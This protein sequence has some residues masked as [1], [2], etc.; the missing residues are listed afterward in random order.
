MSEAAFAELG[1]LLG[2]ARA[3]AALGRSRATHY[4]RLRRHRVGPR[5]AR[6]TPPNALGEPERAAIL[7]VLHEPRFVDEAPAQVY[8]VLLDEGRYLG[9]VSTMYRMLRSADEVR[10]RRRQARHPARAI[11]ELL[12]AGPNR[13]WS[14][15]STKLR[16]PV[17]G[18]WFILLTMLDIFSRFSPGHLVAA[19]EDGEIVKAWIDDVVAT[20]PAPFD[21][22]LLSIHADRGPAMKSEPV[23]ALLD[24][25]GIARSH[26]RPHVSNDNP[27]SEA[28]FKTLKYC[29]TFPE[30][31][32][33][34]EDARAFCARFY[35]KYN[36]E[37]RH[38]G[39]GFHTPA[40][41]HFGTA[42]AVRGG[43]ASVLRAA[44]L[45]HPE[46]FVRGTPVPPAL[47]T[48]AWINE[49]K[50]QPNQIIR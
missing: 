39:I 15:D 30:R 17:R 28:A 26:G 35:R 7:E 33:S 36:F 18:R 27:Y 21:P 19:A 45:T 41:V 4:R 50:E 23:A 1:P 49:P 24:R 14:Y 43:R 44:Y 37:H 13:V 3:C 42:E 40:S 5:P 29:P 38:S 25:L 8:A 22:T 32:G 10:E 48:V 6:P 2:I 46:R 34:L 11:P 47:P 20:Q 12:A 31:F 9:S 16:G